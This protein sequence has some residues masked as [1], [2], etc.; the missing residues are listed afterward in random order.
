MARKARSSLAYVV[1]LAVNLPWQIGGLLALL[2]YWILHDMAVW[3]TFDKGTDMGLAGF[4]LYLIPGLLLVVALISFVRSRQNGDLSIDAVSSPNS[5]A[6]ARM[7]AHDFE[8]LVAEGFRREGFLV[9]E[10]SGTRRLGC[11]D[12]ELFMG[13][14]RYLVQ[15][16]GW[17]ETAV[18]AL[19]VRGL[20]AAISAE[21]AVGGFIVSSGK[22]TDEARKI[23]IGR[24]IRVVPAY[25][26]RR[27]IKK[28]TASSTG[29][30]SIS[31]VFSRRRHDPVPPA[32]P[33]C[34]KVMMRRTKKQSGAVVHLDWGCTGFPACQGS[35]EVQAAVVR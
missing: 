34:G 16:R 2:A 4:S 23:A 7:S 11:V 12:L 18:D 32:C 21:R 1:D 15:C 5:D 26:L 35:R 28:V 20:Y 31:P 6:L 9:V 8:K 27:L 25:S 14:D 3:T 30:I 10:G 33:K 22:F 13:R 17:K 19:A 24:S 29:E